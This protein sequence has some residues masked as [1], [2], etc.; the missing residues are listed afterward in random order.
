MRPLENLTVRLEVEE[1]LRAQSER[2]RLQYA[3]NRGDGV[4]ERQELRF[5]EPVRE[6]TL[7]VQG[8]F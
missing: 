6:V 2:Q 1:V 7:S 3:G 8:V 5:S 4:L